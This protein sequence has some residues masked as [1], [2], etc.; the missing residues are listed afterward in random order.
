[1]ITFSIIKYTEL[2]RLESKGIQ[3]FNAYAESMGDGS[4]KFKSI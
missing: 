2:Q 3:N 1:M 4:K